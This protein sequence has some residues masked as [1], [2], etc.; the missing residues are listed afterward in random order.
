MKLLLVLLLFCTSL[1]AETIELIVTASPG[2]PDDT[3]ARKLEDRIA[4]STDL[5][6]IIVNR[7]GAAHQIGYNYVQQSTRPVLIASTSMI[8]AHDVYR[9]LDLIHHLGYFSNVVF[10][11]A[12]SPYYS[13]A[14]LNTGREIRFGHGGEGSFS[15]QAQTQVCHNIRCLAVPYRSGAEGMLGISSNTIDA[16]AL[17]GYGS[18]NFQ[19]NRLYRTIGEV[20]SSNTW[21]R[22][23][24][25]N[26]DPDTKTKIQT[27]LKQVDRKFYTDLGFK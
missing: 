1:C 25:K 7:P 10:V 17:V 22:L 4:D 2:G 12:N 6:I 20:K 11:A 14:D 8:A 26:I 19:S 27:A 23:F 5:K 16:Y 3:V 15:H 18:S 21:F 9:E 13:L 24:G